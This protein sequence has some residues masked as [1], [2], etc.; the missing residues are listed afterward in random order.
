[1]IWRTFCLS[2]T[3]HNPMK[4]IAMAFLLVAG[5]ALGAAAQNTGSKGI[6]IK[7]SEVPRAVMS[8]FNSSFSNAR[9]ADWKKKDDG[10]MVSFEVNNVDHH[11]KL[12]ASGKVI[13]KGNEIRMAELP[14]AIKASIGKD[15]PRYRIEDIYTMV[16]GETTTYKVELDGA[17]DRKV[18]Y[19]ADGQMLKDMAD[20]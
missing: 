2:L 17:E 4:K 20:D 9:D 3:I 7:S 11:A 19:S 18:V 10:Y 15:Y 14:A 13:M 5:A 12:D 8:S 1:M 16:E 6:E